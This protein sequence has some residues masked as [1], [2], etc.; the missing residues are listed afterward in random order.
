MLAIGQNALDPEAQQGL[1]RLRQTPAG[2]V[3]K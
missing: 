1:H 3:H 2:P